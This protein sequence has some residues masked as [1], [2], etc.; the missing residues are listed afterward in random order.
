M[1]QIL[2]MCDYHIIRPRSLLD[3]GFQPRVPSFVWFVLLTPNWITFQFSTIGLSRGRYLLVFGIRWTGWIP[4]GFIITYSD[5]LQ[6]RW[7]HITDMLHTY[8]QATNIQRA[9]IRTHIHAYI[10]TALAHKHTYTE[11]HS[12]T[13]L[14]LCTHVRI[15]SAILTYP[16]LPQLKN[17]C[18][19]LQCFYSIFTRMPSRHAC[20]FWLIQSRA[21]ISTCAYNQPDRPAHAKLLRTLFTL[22]GHA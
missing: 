2:C 22:I 10:Y 19:S 13:R 12:H 11:P 6:L 20:F 14:H 8:R 4:A 7:W 5:M 1:V 3:P 9:R 16:H 17:S 15:H 21:I 18:Y